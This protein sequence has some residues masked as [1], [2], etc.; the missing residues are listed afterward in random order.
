MDKGIDYRITKLEKSPLQ[1]FKNQNLITKKFGKQGTVVYQAITG[2]RTSSAIAG[3]LEIDRDLFE[4][5]LAFMEESGIVSLEP[6][7]E[8]P[9][10]K[11]PK[12]ISA[13]PE[14]HEFEAPKEEKEIAPIMPQEENV[15]AEEPEEETHE[16]EKP[17]KSVHSLEFEREIE[18]IDEPEPKKEK[19]AEF[20]APE[21][22]IKPIEFE[23]EHKTQKKEEETFELEAEEKPKE[24]PEEITPIESAPEEPEKEPE[25]EPEEETQE[26]PTEAS[27]EEI[28]PV[29]EHEEEGEG[30]TPVEKII[31]EKYGDVGIT[32]YTLID[33]QR[34]AEEIMKQTGLT[35]SKLVEILDFMDEE[36][37]IKLEYPGEKKK[38]APVEQK[39]S[40]QEKEGFNLLVEE[41]GEAPDK[42]KDKSPIEVPMR[43]PLNM[44]ETLYTKSKILL[45]FGDKGG[46]VFE[47][48]NGKTDVLELALKNQ[49]P[50]YEIN[51]MINFLLEQKAI[52]L[53]PL[54]RVEIRKKYGDEGYSVYKVYGKEGVLLYELVDKDMRIKEMAKYI[55]A[56]VPANKDKLSEMFLF[57]HQIL[58]IDLPVDKDLLR[59]EFESA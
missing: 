13:E 53:K 16:E 21:E 30:L 32:V 5:I 12:E 56:D 42:V 28:A 14:E 6:L 43:A 59:R 8:A 15:P 46:K 23:K 9:S 40:A 38:T 34:T 57:I 44:V 26:E 24:E 35:E 33:G 41:S 48:I 20:E 51:A 4:E 25:E 36:G 47:S 55:Y 11:K 10:P 50:I 2:K 7:G 39:P 45:K 3:D 49:V 27:E 19:E 1:R 58:K 54:T 17:K 52:L 29:S 22:E 37:I 31:K 18:P